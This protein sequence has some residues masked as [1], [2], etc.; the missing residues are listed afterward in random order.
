MIERGMSFVI[1]RCNPSVTPAEQL[2]NFEAK[3]RDDSHP[4][5]AFCRPCPVRDDCLEVALTDPTL[6]GVWGGRT[7]RE[8]RRIAELRAQNIPFLN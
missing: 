4:A 5:K 8:R 1:G 3:T 6:K 7:A 2:P